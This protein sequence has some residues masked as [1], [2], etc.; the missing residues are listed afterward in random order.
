MSEPLG[1]LVIGAGDMGGRHAQHWAAAGA[2]VVA[3]SDPDLIRAQASAEL[4]GGGG[5]L[6]A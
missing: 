2:K 6:D 4:N 1:V 3:V 5:V